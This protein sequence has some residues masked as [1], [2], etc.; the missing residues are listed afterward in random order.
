MSTGRNTTIR[1]RHRKTIAREEPP[2]GICGGAI[3]YGLPHHDPK[4]YV[5]DH[6]DPYHHSRDDSISNKQAAHRD[7]NRLKSDKR[8]D[9]V[10]QWRVYETTRTW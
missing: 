2:C 9:H 5:V 7:C 4:S 3:D 6:I 8:P 1:D 10:Q